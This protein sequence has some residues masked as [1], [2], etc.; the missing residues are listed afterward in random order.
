[1]ANEHQTADEALDRLRQLALT[2][3]E[4][5]RVVAQWALE[6]RPTGPS[7]NVADHTDSEDA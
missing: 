3:G 1:M 7:P 6:E 2:S 5:M 4:P